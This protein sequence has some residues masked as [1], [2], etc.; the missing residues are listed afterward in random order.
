MSEKKGAVFFDIDGTWLRWQ[1]FD[2]WIRLAIEFGILPR[3]VHEFAVKE[4]QR[5]LTR[6][7]SFSDFVKILVKSYQQ[8]GRLK[9]VRISD[10]KL[11]AE[12]AMEQRGDHVHVFTRELAS[13][14]KDVGMPCAVISGSFQEA[15]EVFAKA[16]GIEI[17]YGTEHPHENGFFTG[18]EPLVWATQKDEAVK[19][20][21][22]EHDIDLKASVAIGDSVSDAKMCELVGYPICFNPERALLL[23]ARAER[24]P[25]VLEKK[26]IR[27]IFKG[28]SNGLLQERPLSNVLPQ[29]LANSLDLRLSML[30]P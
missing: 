12:R 18:G 14:A 9:G 20:I 1:L 26:D 29:E 10:A 4:R 5:Y 21:A 25:V 30:C 16:N 7:G 19:Q 24:W 3:I 6:Q 2:E 22:L 8:D 28:D 15:V 13:A 17:F 27:L 23:I 11:V